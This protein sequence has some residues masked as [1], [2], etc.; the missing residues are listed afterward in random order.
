MHRECSGTRV[1]VLLEFPPVPMAGPY[2]SF[3]VCHG[4]VL[5]AGWVLCP[6]TG[7]SGVSPLRSCLCSTQA[8]HLF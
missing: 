7:V 1:G 4:L 6:R 2:P 8:E 3:G 5:G